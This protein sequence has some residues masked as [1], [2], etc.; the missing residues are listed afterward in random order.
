[1]GSGVL[2]HGVMVSRAFS[3]LVGGSVDYPPHHLTLAICVDHEL[4]NAVAQ[5][6]YDDLVGRSVFSEA[7]GAG[8]DS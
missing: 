2:S 7:A 8:I 6:S 3:D 5:A 4:A 1:M